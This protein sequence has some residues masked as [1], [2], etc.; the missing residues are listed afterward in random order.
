MK[1]RKRD[2]RHSTT[3]V[4]DLEISVVG[5]MFS[6]PVA[7]K[8]FLFSRL[9]HERGR[10]VHG[11]RVAGVAAVENLSDGGGRVGGHVE[12]SGRVHLDRLINHFSHST[13]QEA[14]VVAER[15]QILF[16]LR[17]SGGL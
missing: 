7:L 9:E 16:P 10:A 15:C 13:K 4:V 11:S 17:R 3:A 12:N 6:V 8:S 5:F 1:H 2:K 14:R